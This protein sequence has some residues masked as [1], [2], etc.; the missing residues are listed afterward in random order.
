MLRL[1]HG[2]GITGA[3]PRPAGPRRRGAGAAGA[4]RA[5]G[6]ARARLLSAAADG[7][8][9]SAP[10]RREG[11]RPTS[12]GAAT[13]RVP[14]GRRATSG[15]GASTASGR[16]GR[17]RSATEATRR[18]LPGGASGAGAGS[19]RGERGAGEGGRGTSGTAGGAAAGRARPRPRGLAAA[20]LLLI[21]N[22]DSF[23][24][25]LVHYLG[26]LGAEVVVRRN[27]ALDVQEAMA[28]R[29]AGIVLS[30]GPCDP[31]QAGICL[32][33]TPP[34]PRRAR[35]FWASASAT[36]P[37]GRPSAAGSCAGEIVHGKLGTMHHEGKGVFAGLPSPF[38]GHALPL[39]GRRAR[40]PARCA[41]GHRLARGRHDHGPAPPRASRSRACSSTPKAS[42]PNTATQMLRNFLDTVAVPA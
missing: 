25:N 3:R 12:A 18:P 27:D 34:R 8:V 38:A 2:A 6:R 24:W 29:P 10:E 20:M 17:G 22:Y 11:G 36:R 13:G 7:A 16:P 37:S 4:G 32:P 23:T 15:A 40:E 1:G 26:E 30:P 35:R 9:A 42:P 28:M 14:A 19:R 41:R 5:A 33:L 39:A 21:D 31:D